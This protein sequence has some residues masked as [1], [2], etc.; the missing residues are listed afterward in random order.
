[1]SRVP[2]VVVLGAGINGACVARELALQHCRVT[3]VDSGDVGGGTTA[4]SS[5]LI[6]GG[7]RYL[8][9][10]QTAL[11]RESLAERARLLRL[12]PEF[13]RPLE[14]RI[15]LRRRLGGWTAA[16]MSRLGR[17]PRRAADRGAWLIGAGL[18][19]Y[20]HLAAPS[21]MPRSQVRRRSETLDPG[22]P[23]EFQW[24]GSYFDA[25]MLHP[26]RFTV[27]LIADAETA[28]NTAGAGPLTVL[29]YRQVERDGQTLVVRDRLRREADVVLEP[30]AVVNA[31][32]PW[33]D[34]TTTALGFNAASRL[35]G[36]KGTHL[37]TF[38][39]ELRRLLGNAAVYAEAGDGRP[40]FILPF[41]DGVLIGTTDLPFTGDPAAAVAS[42]AE[43]EYLLN[44]T[45]NVFPTARLARGDVALHYAGVR[46]LPAS[47]ARTTSAVSRDHAAAPEP[48]APW[49]C[50]TL[51]GGKLTTCR[52]FGEDVAAEVLRRLNRPFASQTRERP[53][54]D[55][56][57]LRYVRRLEDLVERRRMLHFQRHLTVDMLR[58]AAVELASSGVVA[59]ESCDAEIARTA[60][61]LKEHF[62]RVVT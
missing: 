32:G 26:E 37:L 50:F 9:H 7:L 6:H 41:G 16:V 11:V 52:E 54:P 43:I 36:T 40:V 53:I 5:R 49:P 39:A 20:D 23:A 14:F 21:T 59:A 48:E 42:E 18:R 25:Q 61:R 56:A 33:G 2:H 46:P 38:Q 13:V 62:G 28:A 45:N 10:G 29:T 35:A 12:A 47:K 60:A 44:L 31:S 19:F 8:E 55:V 34:V 30:D 57:E 24:V 27:A 4:Y 51:V 22:L 17:P 3:L 1:M 15:P 58:D